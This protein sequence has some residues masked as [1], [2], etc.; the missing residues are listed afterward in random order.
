MKKI[1]HDTNTTR[2][3]ERQVKERQKKEVSH[4]CHSH[5]GTSDKLLIITMV[6]HL[7]RFHSCLQSL[8]LT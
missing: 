4:D 5:W 1:I 6:A 2:V 7:K 3:K 8:V